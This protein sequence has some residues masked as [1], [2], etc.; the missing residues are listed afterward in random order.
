V[1]RE[2]ERWKRRVLSENEFT[3]IEA[4][5]DPPIDG[6]DDVVSLIVAAIKD[7]SALVRQAAAEALGR[8]EGPAVS[9]ALRDCISQE[10]E[11]L[12]REYAI[13]SLGA[14][15]TLADLRLLCDLA[16]QEHDEETLVHTYSAMLCGSSRIALRG[17]AR[18]LESDSPV[19]KSSAANALKF[20]MATL[21][22]EVLLDSVRRES[23]KA[24]K[25]VRKEL[26]EVLRILLCVKLSS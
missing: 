26:E 1:I 3:R 7:R 23:E 15:A 5:D 19:V 24:A 6:G 4:L 2:V 16:G 17:M 14:I 13:S 18:M 25:D 21:C 11:P 9:A 10:Q 22:D 12:V 8:Y 20:M